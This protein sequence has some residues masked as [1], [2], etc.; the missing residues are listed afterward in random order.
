MGG[1]KKSVYIFLCSLLGVMLFLILHRLVIFA[2]LMAVLYG[3][4]GYAAGISYME[5]L[6]VDYATLLL[7]L[8]CGSWYGIWLGS[9]WYEM[10][11]EKGQWR[12]AMFHIRQKL[13]LRKTADYSLKE[14]IEVV[15]QRLEDDLSQAEELAAEIPQAILQS[16][17]V[18]R[19][20]PAGKAGI[21]KKKP[22][23]RKPR[24]KIAL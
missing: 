21:V 8:L 3:A 10:V 6:A 13:F 2:Y 1:V 18:K 22:A 19:R 24:A 16:K 14:K 5:F 7:A 11:Y 20:L 9:Y 4:P 12:G 23:V 15:K 17:T